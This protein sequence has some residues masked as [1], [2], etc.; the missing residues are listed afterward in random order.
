MPNTSAAK[1]SLRQSK[2]REE[3]NL[4]KKEA[5]L[6]VI[7]EIKKLVA[8]GKKAEAAKKLPQAYKIF[9]KAAKAGYIAKNN[10]ARNKSRLTALV[11]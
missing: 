8:G 3:K 4:K 1:K 7:R 9:D 6:S 10:A 2:R 11:K 5:M